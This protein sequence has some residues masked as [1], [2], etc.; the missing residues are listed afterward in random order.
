MSKSVGR[1][2]STAAT[3]MAMPLVV[4]VVDCVPPLVDD[5]EVEA[6]PEVPVVCEEPDEEVLPWLVVELEELPL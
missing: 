4:D 2:P 5:P 3:V 6:E 1:V